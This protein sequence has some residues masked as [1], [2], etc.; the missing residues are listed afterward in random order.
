MDKLLRDKEEILGKMSED[1]INKKINDLSEQKKTIKKDELYDILHN[2]IDDEIQ[3][4]LL[5]K[6]KLESIDDLIERLTKTPSFKLSMIKGDGFCGLYAIMLSYLCLGKDFLL[7]NKGES[8]DN[9]E[10]FVKFLDEQIDE[11]LSKTKTDEYGLI[12]DLTNLKKQINDKTILAIESG[13]LWTLLKEIFNCNIEIYYETTYYKN[14]YKYIY[15]DGRGPTI[16]IY[17]NG[18]HYSSIIDKNLKPSNVPSNAK[19]WIENMKDI[20]Y[21]DVDKETHKNF[22]ENYRFVIDDVVIN[23]SEYTER[24]ADG[25]K[26]LRRKSLR[27]K[28]L[29]RKSLKKKS[30]RRKSLRRKS[31]KKKSLKKKLKT[32]FIKI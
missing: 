13:S 30:L 26:S 31:L 12:E 29:R 14:K 3:R 24:I 15:N 9:M 1:D 5:I 2:S 20:N 16:R 6:I 7:N 17:G 23:P 19:E 10:N 18:V 25:N 27:R 22:K 11:K 28:S 32:K 21:T 4:L 8:I